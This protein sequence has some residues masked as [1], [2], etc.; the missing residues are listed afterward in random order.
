MQEKKVFRVL[1][2]ER[3]GFFVDTEAESVD[4][5]LARVRA[6]LRDPEDDVQPIED[7][8]SYEGYVVEHAV[9]INRSD[10]QLDI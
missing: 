10:A 2:G 8:S 1:I 9:E 6:R 3:Q 5:A 7:N 4:D